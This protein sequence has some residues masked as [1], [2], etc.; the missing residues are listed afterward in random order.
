MDSLAGS[1]NATVKRLYRV[2]CELLP[3]VL[4]LIQVRERQYKM[5]LLAEIPRRTSDRIAIKAQQREEQVRLW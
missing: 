5:K 2:L 3:D 4:K 1:K